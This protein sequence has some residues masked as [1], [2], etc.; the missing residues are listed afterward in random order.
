MP[1]ANTI[2][3]IVSFLFCNFWRQKQN[4]KKDPS[5]FEL[6]DQ[7][8]KSQVTY[9]MEGFSQ[10]EPYDIANMQL[11]S[12]YKTSNFNIIQLNMIIG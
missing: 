5:F 1:A 11:F 7:I 8:T 9:T 4:W 2:L 6:S 10:V 3:L 12:I